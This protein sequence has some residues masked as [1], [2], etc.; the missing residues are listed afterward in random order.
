MSPTTILKLPRTA[1]LFGTFVSIPV[2]LLDKNKYQN[3]DQYRYGNDQIQ[4]P[5]KTKNDDTFEPPEAKHDLA[6]S[7]LCSVKG[8]MVASLPRR[9]KT[10][11]NKYG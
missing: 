9:R 2:L 5:E 8:D 1:V 3:Y 4:D 7:F 6:L 10:G 11:N